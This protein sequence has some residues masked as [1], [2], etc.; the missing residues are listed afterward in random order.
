M[1]TIRRP[2]SV[3][4]YDNCAHVARI[5]ADRTVATIAG[6]QWVG[7]TGGY[8][9]SKYRITGSAHAAIVAAMSDDAQETA[10]NIIFDNAR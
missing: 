6:V 10:W 8:H 2:T 1:E 7:N 3:G 5:Y 9:E 4:I